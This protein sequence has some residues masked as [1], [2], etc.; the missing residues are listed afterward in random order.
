MVIY[1]CSN[2]DTDLCEIIAS[3]AMFLEGYME[4]LLPP[5]DYSPI[6]L[7]LPDHCCYH[8]IIT[9]IHSPEMHIRDDLM[10]ELRFKT[11]NRTFNKPRLII[12]KLT[13]KKFLNDLLEKVP[14]VNL[15]VNIHKSECVF[16]NTRQTQNV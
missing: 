9:C 11:S 5:H 15:V 16:V 1:Q 3:I 4:E 8:K 12:G 6:L 7:T 14:L 10:V 13:N 2:Y